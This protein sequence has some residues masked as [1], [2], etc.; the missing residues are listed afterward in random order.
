[1]NITKLKLTIGIVALLILI[2]NS[3]FAYF[4]T[5]QKATRLTAETFLYTVTYK[6]GFEKRE[7]YMPIMAVRGLGFS[8][9]SPLVGYQI[10]NGNKAI[11]NLGVS[12]SIVL[13]KNKD[14]V[15]KDN[16]YYLPSQK[17]AEFTLV[18]LLTIPKELQTENLDLSMLV[19]N[20]P[21][22]MI[23]DGTPIKAQLNPSEL[24]Y[25]RT[26]VIDLGNNGTIV[27][28]STHT[29]STK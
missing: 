10:M 24:Q 29:L 9:S 2:P 27:A 11:S 8:T 23:Q 15:I 25:Y 14:V 26:P 7:L 4:T 6:F 28:G 16:Q 22:T 12:N 1:M 13:T 21:F 17:V 18:T 20:L 3:S 5:D 19:T